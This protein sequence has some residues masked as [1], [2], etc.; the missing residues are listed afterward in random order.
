MSYEY[1]FM[2]EIDPLLPEMEDRGVS[3]VARGP[4]GFL[5][6][7]RKAKSDPDRLSPKWA[8]KRAGFIRRHMAQ[9]KDNDEPLW[10]HDPDEESNAM[11][12]TRR[13]LALIAWAYTPHKS[14]LFRY[15]DRLAARKAPVSWRRR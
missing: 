12:P 2:D 5:K 15:L 9:V 14:R 6:Q 8:V 11:R 13:H 3:E 10:E 1:L 4:D 7:W